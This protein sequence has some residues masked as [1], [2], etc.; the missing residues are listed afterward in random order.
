MLILSA[1]FISIVILLKKNIISSFYANFFYNLN[2][3]TSTKIVEL[4]RVNTIAV[5]Y[6]IRMHGNS[7][8]KEEIS[9]VY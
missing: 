2:N 3:P 1:N 9:R 5:C 4:L 6:V 8:N 7:K